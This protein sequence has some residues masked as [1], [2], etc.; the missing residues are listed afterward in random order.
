[1]RAIVK[2]TRPLADLDQASRVAEELL[3]TLEVFSPRWFAWVS[4]QGR[5]VQL[6]EAM[7]MTAVLE[8]N[9]LRR[10]GDRTTYS[11]DLRRS[12][13]PGPEDARLLVV[14]DPTFQ[15]E[16]LVLT[17]GDRAAM[18]APKLEAWATA[19]VPGPGGLIDA[20]LI[21]P[22]VADKGAGWLTFRRGVAP[23]PCPEGV[24]V[25]ALDDGWLV[26]AHAFAPE[27]TSPEALLAIRSVGRAWGWSPPGGDPGSPPAALPIVVPTYLKR[28]PA[29][30]KRSAVSKPARIAEPAAVINPDDTAML[31]SPLYVKPALP[32]SGETTPERLE[33]IAG[34]APTTE[35]VPKQ[36][37][38]GFDP[39]ETAMVPS[40]LAKAPSTG[41]FRDQLG[42]VDIP[43]LSLDEYADMRAQ[44]AVQGEDHAETLERFGVMSTA[45][46]AALKA[47]FAAYFKRD[48]EAQ[49]RFVSALQ[50]RMGGGT[51]PAT[52]TPSGDAT[53]E[54]DA[55]SVPDVLA[56]RGIPFSDAAPASAVLRGVAE[57]AGE[58]SRTDTGTEEIDLRK[59][60]LG[61]T[62]FDTTQ[63]DAEEGGHPVS[64]RRDPELRSLVSLERFAEIQA[65]LS[66]SRDRDGVLEHYG[67]TA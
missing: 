33:E 1:V 9:R 28:Q 30:E 10:S 51:E 62:P 29:E 39:D 25:R 44:L 12:A 60:D 4:R 54:I 8:G 35:R 24:D 59:L 58:P 34:P 47:R 3:G 5:H 42:A 41:S 38:E 65:A 63:V 64:S 15:G 7:A 23:D 46:H 14:V 19:L 61:A 57:A 55:D 32:F 66:R 36:R 37:K 50:P 13:G 26:M 53:A 2:R 67:F 31:P 48:P 45:V 56:E 20:F 21:S 43:T 18:T 40:P 17:L 22:V 6:K 16:S 49:Q 52:A 11:F 27:S